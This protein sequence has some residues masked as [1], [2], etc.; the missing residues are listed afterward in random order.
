MSVSGRIV[1]IFGNMVTAE[2]D[3]AVRQNAV[4]YC[5]RAD[6]VRLMAEIIRIRGNRADM[7][8]FELTRGLKVGDTVGVVLA[9]SAVSTTSTSTTFS[10]VI[11]FPPQLKIVVSRQSGSRIAISKPRV[12]A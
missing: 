12:P 1:T 2:F 11:V 3:G 6:G 4:A 9:G 10:S 7:Q 5:H 8:V